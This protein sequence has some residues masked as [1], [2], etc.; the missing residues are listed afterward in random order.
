MIYLRALVLFL[1]DK[2]CA[3]GDRD[4]ETM[5]YRDTVALLRKLDAV[6]WEQWCGCDESGMAHKPGTQGFRCDGRPTK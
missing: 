4:P 1:A 5:S 3:W 2:A 6:K